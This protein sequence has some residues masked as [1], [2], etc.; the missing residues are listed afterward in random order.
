MF[1]T[2][3]NLTIGFQAKK[4]SSVGVQVFFLLFSIVVTNNWQNFW[5]GSCEIVIGFFQRQLVVCFF[6]RKIPSSTQNISTKNNI[7]FANSCKNSW[8]YLRKPFEN[9]YRISKKFLSLSRQ[10]ARKKYCGNLSKYQILHWVLT[11]PS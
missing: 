2:G 1:Y 7:N 8:R 6:F 11:K 4:K 9:L 5:K 3:I 10:I